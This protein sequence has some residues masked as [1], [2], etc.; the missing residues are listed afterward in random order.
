MKLLLKICLALVV[1]L[2]IGVVGFSFILPRQIMVTKSVSIDAKPEKVFPYLNNPADWKRWSAWN[3]TYDPSLIYMYGGPLSGKGARQGWSGD[4]TGNW[5]MVF[6]NATA[7]DSLTYDLKETG[8]TIVAKGVITLQQTG[9]STL[10]TWHQSMPLEDN[11][12]ALYEGLWKQHRTEQE[13]QQGLENLKTLI[14]DT[15]HNTAK[16]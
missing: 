6:T 4:K 11:M 16:K 10:V 3:K 15:K 12:L 13:V 8:T 5:Q 14:S 7:P 2:V 9:D 1:V